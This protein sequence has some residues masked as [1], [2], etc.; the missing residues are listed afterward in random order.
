MICSNC[1]CN[2]KDVSE[3][4]YIVVHEVMKDYENEHNFFCCYRCMKGWFS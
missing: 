1:E 4:N 2:I 3:G